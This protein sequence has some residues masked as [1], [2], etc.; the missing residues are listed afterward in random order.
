M[1][2]IRK[3]T[4]QHSLTISESYTADSES[5]E[6]EKKRERNPHWRPPNTA[7][8]PT[9][10]WSWRTGF[11]GICIKAHIISSFIFENK[12]RHLSASATADVP[13]CHCLKSHRWS[14]VMYDNMHNLSHISVVWSQRRRLRRRQQGETAQVSLL[15]RKSLPP[16]GGKNTANQNRFLGTHAALRSQQIALVPIHYKKKT[17]EE[18]RIGIEVRE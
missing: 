2:F 3:M 18:N 15:N 14:T 12:L 10:L 5:P 6:E 13:G 11:V 1:A 4:A 8:A 9:P 16:L 17:T 7:T